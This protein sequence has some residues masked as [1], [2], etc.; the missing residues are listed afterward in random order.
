MKEEAIKYAIRA[1]FNAGNEFGSRSNVE[2]YPYSKGMVNAID[3]A[4]KG[5][6]EAH[7]SNDIIETFKTSVHYD[8][9]VTTLKNI[10]QNSL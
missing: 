1:A 7:V 4:L 5:L 10:H 3:N 8:T 2:F 9:V 6:E